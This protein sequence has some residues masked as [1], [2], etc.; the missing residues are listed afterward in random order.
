MKLNVKERD[1]VAIAAVNDSDDIVG[2]AVIKESI[3]I[4]K[5]AAFQPI[6][7]DSGSIA[8][9]LIWN[10]CQRSPQALSNGIQI[11][12]WECNSEAQKIV[13]KMRLPFIDD[14]PLLFSKKIITGN[15]NKIFSLTGLGY[16]GM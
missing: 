8:E 5:F 9:V 10:C 12:W 15:M 16:L 7:A 1:T 4:N 2:Y 11:C 3:T 6:Y 14:S 13:D